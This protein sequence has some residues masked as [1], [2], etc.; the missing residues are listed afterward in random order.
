MKGRINTYH[1]MEKLSE[2][3]N[4]SRENLYYLLNKEE[5]IITCLLTSIIF[6]KHRDLDF[7]SISKFYE[8]EKVELKTN[9]KD[10]DFKS[11]YIIERHEEE[12]RKGYAFIK[13]YKITYKHLNKVIEEINLL[14]NIKEKRFKLINFI[15]NNKGEKRDEK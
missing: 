11:H 10:F 3:L 2:D 7:S 8:N 1:T 9:I 5:E 6:Q 12:I 4:I 13:F 15:E 14:K